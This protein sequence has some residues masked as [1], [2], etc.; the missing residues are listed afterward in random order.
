MPQKGSLCLAPSEG[1]LGYR[2]GLLYSSPWRCMAMKSVHL[3]IA[4]P[5]RGTEATSVVL[6]ARFHARTELAVS[7]RQVPTMGI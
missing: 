2:Q 4:F 6:C 7:E 3:D 1:C 5:C